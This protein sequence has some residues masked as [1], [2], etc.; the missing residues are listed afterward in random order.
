MSSEKTILLEDGVRKGDTQALAQVFA[1]NRERLLLI[2]TFRLDHR[3]SGRITPDD[4]LQDAWMAAVKRIDHYRSFTGSV[5]VWLSLIVK[6]T[7]V[8]LQRTHL[9][10]QKRDVG[11]E[12]LRQPS[13]SITLAHHLLGQASS[14]SAA[15]IQMDMMARVENAIGTMDEGDQEI[16]AMRHFE[17]FSNKEAAEALEI[18]QKAASIRYVRALQRL[19]EI[20][21]EFSV[22]RG[23]GYDER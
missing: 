3:L 15:V 16:L 1:D 2:V 23:G 17:E 12:Q 11:R 5:F 10:A 9:A 22:F 21:A 19:K 20:M 8:D 7:M 14:P 13:M 4:V 6:Q 18:S